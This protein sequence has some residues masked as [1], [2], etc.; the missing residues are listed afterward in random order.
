MKMIALSLNVHIADLNGM[1]DFDWRWNKSEIKKDKEI[2]VFSTFSCGGGSS[3]GYKRAGF[4]VIGNVE[5]DPK[6]NDLYITNNK[7]KYNFCEDLRV[8][9]LRDDL[10]KELYHLDILDGSPPCTSFSTAGVR[11]RDWNKEKRFREG[12]AYQKLDDLF[13]VFLDTV[14]KLQPK[15]VIA[16]NVVG[17]VK[18]KA[19]GYVNLILKRFR[20]LGYNVQ[21]FKLNSAYMN[22]PQA[23]ERIFFI[24]NRMGFEK[25]ELSFNESPIVFKEVRSEH[26]KPFK[27]KNSYLQTLIEKAGPNDRKMEDVIERISGE[28][29]KY[30]TIPIVHDSQV[31][32]TVTSGGN[33]FRYCDRLLLSDEDFRNVQSFPQDY[34]FKGNNVQYVCGMS[35]PPNMMANVAKEVYRQWLS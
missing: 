11:E 6:I 33:F 22:V 16:E 15:I 1:S 5:I 30:F 34:D 8:F 26:G 29:G 28:K 31:S 27:D 21:A 7:P 2:K 10:P 14:E 9:N 25:L 17:I 12:Q 19:K 20:S 18:G 24:A 3:L 13:F 4:D 32:P 23:R 35:V